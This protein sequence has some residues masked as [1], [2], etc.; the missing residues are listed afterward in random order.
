ME[1]DRMAGLCSRCVHARRIDSDRGSTFILCELSRTNG[2]F[3]KYPR[4]PIVSCDGFQILAESPAKR[5]S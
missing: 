4:L 5:S 1:Y 2:L 3:A